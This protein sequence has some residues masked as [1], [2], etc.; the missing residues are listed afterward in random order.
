MDLPQFDGTLE[1]SFAVHEEQLLAWLR[2]HKVPNNDFLHHLLLSLDSASPHVRNWFLLHP[3]TTRTT[4]E[5]TIGLLREFFDGPFRSEWRRLAARNRLL[6]IGKE[7]ANGGTTVESILNEFLESATVAGLRSDEELRTGFTR[8]AS[9]ASVLM[10]EADV[11]EPSRCFDR[12]R[13]PLFE[14]TSTL[15]E[16]VAVAFDWEYRNLISSVVSVSPRHHEL[17]AMNRDQQPPATD[18]RTMPPPPP[19]QLDNA[20]RTRHMALPPPLSPTQS[21]HAH[22]RSLSSQHQFP[23][24]TPSPEPPPAQVDEGYFPLLPP[25]ASFMRVVQ[26]G[27]KGEMRT[28]VFSAFSSHSTTPMERSTPRNELVNG[29]ISRRSSYTEGIDQFQPNSNFHHQ[30]QQNWR[31]RSQTR[32]QTTYD[33][34][35]ANQSTPLIALRSNSFVSSIRPPQFRRHSESF[36]RNVLAQSNEGRNFSYPMMRAS[37][38]H[39][40][41]DDILDS[42][43][44]P[45]F[46]DDDDGSPA[47]NSRSINAV[48]STTQEPGEKLSST[49]RKLVRKSIRRKPAELGDI[50]QSPNTSHNT[51]HSGSSQSHA[52]S[53]SLGF[54]G[55]IF[56][57]SS[58]SGS[59]E[60]SSHQQYRAGEGRIEE[61]GLEK[62]MIS[63][64]LQPYEFGKMGK[65]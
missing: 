10:I 53:R 26:P 30:N 38:T 39:T 5:A 46:D 62:G 32:P 41:L 21:L 48:D 15:A 19:L 11:G 45:P 49:S 16:A 57:I 54:I 34:P 55:K 18:S 61:G 1:R 2:V 40:I 65:I 14:A 36:N 37:S 56:R 42:S 47:I 8:R 24:F 7:A 6:R 59:K 31:T 20:L 13:F 28:G 22:R 29:A 51:S 33:Y 4:F 60:Q 43:P 58:L 35:L 17:T 12:D 9:L 23:I 63:S 50:S 52:R 64:P 44:R 25:A 3:A 27:R